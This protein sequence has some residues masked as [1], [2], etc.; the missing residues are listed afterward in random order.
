M[1]AIYKREVAS[2]LRNFVGMLFIAILL[3][4]IGLY[5]TV[6][7]LI[8]GYPYFTYAV[9]G[10]IFL[11][12]ICIPI[13][14]MRSLSEERHSKTDQ[15]ILTAPV[16]VGGIVIGK[17]LALLTVFAVPT[18]IICFYPLIMRIFGSVPMAE[19][20]LGVLA[21][22][23]FGM[24][25]LSIGLFISSITESQV[26]AAVLSFGALFLGYMMSSICSLI[27]TTGNL[28][29]RILSCYDL[30]T[31]YTMLLNGTLD[32]G[33]VIY[34]FSVTGLFLFL[35]AQSIQKRRYSV[36]VKNLR[37]GAYSSG[38]IAV[39]VAIVVVL[40]VLVGEMPSTWTSLDVTSGQIYSLTDQTK[41]YVKNMQEDVTIYVLSNEDSCDTTLKQTLDRYNDLSDHITVE[42]VDPTINPAF[43][44]KYTASSVSM[45]SL[46]V[47]SEKR[48]K[49]VYSSSI[50]ESSYDYDYYTGSY[51]TTTTGYDGEGQ[52]TSALDYVLTD[53][54]PKIYMTEGHGEYTLSSSFSTALDK[55][56]I[57]SETINLLNYE[58]IP[59][60]AACV[61]INAAT[62]DLSSDDKDKIIAYLEK[63]GKVVVVTGYTT[64]PLPNLEDLLAY[65]G[66]YKADG[67]VLEQDEDLYYRVPFYL[68]PEV[69]SSKY[70]A[71]I[72]GKYYVFTPYA[73]GILTG[74]E[75]EDIG[76]NQFLYTSDSAFAKADTSNAQD[77]QKTEGDTD[78]P[79]AIGVEA[80]KTVGESEA[81][82]VVF[83]CEQI[84]TDDANVVVS[85]AN[86]MLFTNT[87]GSF[88]DHEVSVSIPAK[89]YEV[90][91]LTLT[92]AQIVRTALCT[93]ILL[94]VGFI[95][96]GFLIWFK[97]RKR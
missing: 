59:E 4:F 13:L 34:Y 95:V 44:Q 50:Y 96:T 76:Y 38:M 58:A 22:F 53:E 61:M 77:F 78:G 42:Y 19:S 12:L 92:E 51:T 63:G 20:Y 93:T 6:Y 90:S 40:N 10:V 3:A 62:T 47:V 94:P 25:C 83:G 75:T 7:N 70:T 74:E 72:Y 84:F 28:L 11:L 5:F 85:G 49:I 65:M 16:S 73:Q 97:R 57:E 9:S 1:L 26:I 55:E 29:T 64:E 41:E 56:N 17:F 81:V 88:V 69:G 35:T 2:Y 67:L 91:N 14:S 60:D 79:F 52:I 66:L 80:T 86:Q 37:F 27:S 87:L 68:L 71:G 48:S 30:Y 33:S 45:N 24:T 15:L 43:V 82:M 18:V 32:I 39:A 54:M 21:F 36:S 89:S 31:P 8:N 46:I 23:L